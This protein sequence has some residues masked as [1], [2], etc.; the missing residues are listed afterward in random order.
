[1]VGIELQMINPTLKSEIQY[2]PYGAKIVKIGP[3]DL[4]ILWLRATKSGKKQNW[5]P[6]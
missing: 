1:M 4:E 2:L 6:W 3:T 5:L